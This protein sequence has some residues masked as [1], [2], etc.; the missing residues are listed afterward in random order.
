[1][2]DCFLRYLHRALWISDRVRLE[3][4]INK[5]EAYL[6]DE[7]KDKSLAIDGD[8]AKIVVEFS[9]YAIE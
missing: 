6:P 2:V 3:D 8:I 1:M 4:R 7:L 5:G 9:N